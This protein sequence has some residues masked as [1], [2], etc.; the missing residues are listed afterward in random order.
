MIK[1]ECAGLTGSCVRHR[2]TKGIFFVNSLFL[3]DLILTLVTKPLQQNLC[4]TILSN[5]VLDFSV[6]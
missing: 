2:D 6:K 5:K 3:E 4:H 1:R